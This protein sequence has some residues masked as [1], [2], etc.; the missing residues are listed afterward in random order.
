MKIKQLV[1]KEDL[2]YTGSEI[3]IAKGIL[4]DFVL[5]K[6]IRSEKGL[7]FLRIDDAPIGQFEL[8][9]AIKKANE[10]NEERYNWL[11]DLLKRWEAE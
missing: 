6:N 3:F 5:K 9:Q 8:E 10:K 11:K 1:F 7:Y 2:D 4:N